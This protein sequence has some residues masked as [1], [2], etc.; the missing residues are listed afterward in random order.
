MSAPVYTIYR[1][2]CKVNGKMYI[3]F[4]SA[5]PKRQKDHIR[6]ALKNKRECLFHRAIRKYGI[7]EFSW[8]I[9]YQSFDQKHTLNEMEPHFIKEYK[10][11]G[12]CGYNMTIGG[13]GVLG[14][15]ITLEER[16][17][18]SKSHAGVPLSESHRNNIAKA[19][20]GK[21]KTKEHSQNAAKAKKGIKF[22]EDHKEALSK[23]KLGK[24]AKNRKSVTIN[25]VTYLSK[26]DA[27]SRLNI[28]WRQ[29]E[30]ILNGK[31]T[32]STPTL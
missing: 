7:D 9:L 11:F 25:G 26:S 4:D 14:R 1:A 22:S 17:K 19:H 8:D 2:T 24:P 28:S 23:A 6:D 31:I 15:T 5:Y 21:P 32:R 12:E 29:V 18:M 13:E 16:Q 30:N 3:G 20:K 10:T 27:A